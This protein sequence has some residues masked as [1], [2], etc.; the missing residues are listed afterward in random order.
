MD[1]NDLQSSAY[2]KQIRYVHFL[3]RIDYDEMKTTN[4]K[5]ENGVT[6]HWAERLPPNRPPD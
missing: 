2:L 1:T 5:Q 3:G 6:D 4:I